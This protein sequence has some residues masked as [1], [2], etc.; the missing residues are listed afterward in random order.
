MYLCV[1]DL[2]IYAWALDKFLYMF[3]KIIQ[4]VQ[5]LWKSMHFFT[6]ILLFLFLGILHYLCICVMQE[7]QNTL[8]VYIQSNVLAGSMNACFI[9]LLPPFNSIFTSFYWCCTKSTMW[10]EQWK[11][12]KRTNMKISLQALGV[13]MTTNNGEANVHQ[14]LKHGKTVL[15]S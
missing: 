12:I 14:E 13:A 7:D 15:M 8:M 4:I 10:G 9:V 3:K 1:C 2:F 11:Q 6:Q 5:N